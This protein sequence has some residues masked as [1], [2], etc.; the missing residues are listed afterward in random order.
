MT[1]DDFAATGLNRDSYAGGAQSRKIP[2]K[3]L[4]QRYGNLKG[5]L[6]KDFWEWLGYDPKP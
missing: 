4:G 3:D 2:L 5:A 6:S 1:H